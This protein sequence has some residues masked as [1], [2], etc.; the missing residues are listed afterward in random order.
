MVVI[1]ISTRANI[2]ARTKPAVGHV[3]C[4]INGDNCKTLLKSTEHTEYTDLLVRATRGQ[5]L[6]IKQ[7]TKCHPPRGGGLISVCSV[8]SK[9]SFATTT[10]D[11]RR[12][13]YRFCRPRTE[14]PCD[15]SARAG[16]KHNA[17][18]IPPLRTS[19]ARGGFPSPFA[20]ACRSPQHVSRAGWMVPRPGG[21]RP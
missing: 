8:D 6:D 11:L 4:I 16:P 15:C 9:M 7:N 13:P 21:Y 14:Q 20:S 19:R 2:H 18:N 10:I 17:R 5:A 3:S 1:L 12:A